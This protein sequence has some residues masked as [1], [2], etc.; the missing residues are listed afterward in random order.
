MVLKIN[1]MFFSSLVGTLK[2]EGLAIL[3]RA[4]YI[5]YVN[6]EGKKDAENDD[7]PEIMHKGRI[8]FMEVIQS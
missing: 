2:Y 4:E 3:P 8:K 7:I 5:D 6:A 1:G